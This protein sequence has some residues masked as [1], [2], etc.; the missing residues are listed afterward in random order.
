MSIS[1]LSKFL[2]SLSFFACSSVFA[3]LLTVDVTGIQSV[4]ELDDPNNTVLTFDIGPNSRITSISYS[5]DVTALSP[6]WLS[7]LGLY[8]S[9]SKGTEGIYF[10]PGLPDQDPGS[11]SYSDSADLIAFGLD[12]KIGNDGIL[13]LEFF[14]DFDDMMGVDGIWNFG[15]ITFG[16]EEQVVDVPE[17]SSILLLGAGLAMLGYARRRRAPNKTLA[18]LP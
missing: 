2:V 8:F 16:Y 9:N 7:E 4:G 15:T 10:N 13:R 14:E 17:P 18:V 3:G 11:A 5:V 6:S 1:S 12:F